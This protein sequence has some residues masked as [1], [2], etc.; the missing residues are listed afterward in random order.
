MVL[1]DRN[2]EKAVEK[3]VKECAEYVTAMRI[4]LERK[5]LMAQVLFVDIT[6]FIELD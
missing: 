4:E 2:Q 5:K 6:S 1:Q 3:I